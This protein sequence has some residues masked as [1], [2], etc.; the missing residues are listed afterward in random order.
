[1]DSL[2][3]KRMSRSRTM[4]RAELYRGVVIG[5]LL[6]SA[7]FLFYLYLLVPSSDTWDIG[8]FVIQS[9][10]FKTV[11]VFVWSLLNKSVFLL[12]TTLWFFTASQWWRY[13]ILVP[14]TLF[15][16]QLSG[17]LNQQLEYIDQYDF[18]YSLPIV[19]PI[20]IAMII[21]SIKLNKQSKQ[22]DLRDRITNK[23]EA[24]RNSQDV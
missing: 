23:I 2:L 1:M 21:I 7:P 22:L 18:W 20:V 10:G 19:V 13:C 11:Q 8:I 17:V 3:T 14:F 6:I 24:I 5:L 9:G 12:I 4:D 16:F 15:L